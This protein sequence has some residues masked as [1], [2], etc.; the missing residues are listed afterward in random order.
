LQPIRPAAL[1]RSPEDRPALDQAGEGRNVRRCTATQPALIVSLYQ[2]QGWGNYS[3]SQSDR[4]VDQKTAMAEPQRTYLEVDQQRKAL[5][6]SEHEVDL[7]SKCEQEANH[8]EE[9][10][11][12]Y[13]V[14]DGCG[15][16]PIQEIRYKSSVV[17]DFDLCSICEEEGKYEDS[18]A[19]FLKIRTPDKTP[20]SIVTILAAVNSQVIEHSEEE[21]GEV[22]NTFEPTFLH[23][24]VGYQTKG[25]KPLKA[26]EV[27]AFRFVEMHYMIPADFETTNHGVLSGHCYEE[28]VLS[29]Y[30]FGQ[31]QLKQGHDEQRGVE[32]CIT[33]GNTG[34]LRSACPDGF[35]CNCA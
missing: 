26:A 11:H 21:E 22:A 23:E 27:R 33:C 18:Y 31:L 13:V 29:A 3:P 19:P 7:D 25:K 34:H 9:A 32:I 4:V 5:I 2:T 20:K 35:W 28:R 17:E 12:K 14:C 8:G 24:E 16:N 30:M 15:M 10:L 6:G 1:N